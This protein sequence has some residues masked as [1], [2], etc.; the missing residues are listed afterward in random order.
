MFGGG[1]C[2]RRY[3]RVMRTSYSCQ[4]LRTLSSVHAVC[5]SSIGKSWP[6]LRPHS[7]LLQPSHRQQSSSFVGEDGDRGGQLQLAHV[8]GDD[9]EPLLSLTVD[10]LLKRAARSHPD[11]PA[12][13]CPE[14]AA[15]GDGSCN[16]R[17]RMSYAELDGAVEAAARGLLALGI[18]PGDRVGTWLPN[19][20]EYVVLQFATAR[21]GAVLTTMNP[22]Y[23]LPEL[24]HAMDTTQTKMLV[25]VPGIASS[26]YLQMVRELLAHD[27][28]PAT[29]ENIIVV[30]GLMSADG[31]TGDRAPVP[32][33]AEQAARS[34]GYPMVRPY[35]DL[36]T[37]AVEMIWQDG[38]VEPFHISEV[39]DTVNIQ[40]TSGTTGLPKAVALSHRNIVNNAHF[41]AQ[42]Q[43]LTAMDRICVPVPMYHCFGVVMGSLAA[44]STSA[45]LVFPSRTFNPEK[46][47][48]AVESEGCT[49]LYGVPTMF[50]AELAHENFANYDLGTLRTGIMAGS[51]RARPRP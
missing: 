44:V 38:I 21:M 51:V 19:V 46:T 4:G 20:P 43:N 30:P 37:A 34:L 41:V 49:A 31:D 32:V 12:L 13:I 11:A 6:A 14:E 27:D 35:S 17:A 28:R 48:A 1:A 40:F 18:R 7:H 33:D 36:S 15:T 5:G 2:A 39:A 25:I 16:S 9:S 8:R 29:L 24:I 42:A 45:A 50:I 3:T 23:R 22:A 26:D 10:E 47:L